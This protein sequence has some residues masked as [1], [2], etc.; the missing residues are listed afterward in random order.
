MS[1]IKELASAFIKGAF[2]GRSIA[3]RQLE[4]VVD[5]PIEANPVRAAY[6]KTL[7]I[8][9]SRPELILMMHLHE[10]IKPAE[11]APPQW[12]VGDDVRITGGHVRYRISGFNTKDFT[13]VHA[14]LRAGCTGCWCPVSKLRRW[15]K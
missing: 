14:S 10:K 13:E 1:E 6:Y 4:S 7:D 11:P 5:F 15:D 3:L 12:K 2:L 8:I 9:G